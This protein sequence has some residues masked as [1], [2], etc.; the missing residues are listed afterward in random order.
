MVEQKVKWKEGD[1]YIVAVSDGRGDGPIDIST[2]GPNEGLDREQVITIEALGGS[3]EAKQEVFVRQQGKRV[4]FL[5]A[6]GEQ[7]ITADNR[8]FNVLK[9]K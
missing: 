1:G 3:N 7:L 4:R 9:Q 2:D 8:R 5:T 6:D